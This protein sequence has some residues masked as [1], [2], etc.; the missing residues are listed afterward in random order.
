MEG[1]FF[2]F[3]TCERLRQ[4]YFVLYKIATGKDTK[5]FPSILSHLYALFVYASVAILFTLFFWIAVVSFI[6]GILCNALHLEDV[7]SLFLDSDTSVALVGDIEERYD[8]IVQS[9]KYGATLWYIK[10][11]I[12]SLPPLIWAAMKKPLAALIRKIGS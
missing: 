10:Q 6:L 4:R 8:L 2:G 7:Y 3:D 11:V 12:T 5:L 9:G 1:N